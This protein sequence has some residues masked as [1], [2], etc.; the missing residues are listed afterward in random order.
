MG[1]DP[2]R[3]QGR[4][5]EWNCPTYKISRRA[6]RRRR[7]QKPDGLVRIG[8]AGGSRTHQHDFAV[9]AQAVARVLRDRSHCR[10]VLFRSADGTVPIL[11]VEEFPELQEIEDRIEW[12]N[13]VPLPQLPEKMVL[14]DVNLA[15]LETGN[16]FCEAKSELKFFEAALVDVPTIA[17]PTGP[18][19]RAIRDGATGFLAGSS[20]DWYSA[21]LRLIDDQ[22][23]R[24]RV[25]RA[26]HRTVLGRYGPFRRADAMLS[27]LPQFH[28]NSRD[29]TR[30]FALELHRGTAANL[31]NINIAEAVTVFDFDEFGDADLTVVIPLHNYA[32]YV[33]EAL[34]SVRAQTL[35]TLDL[36]VVE[37]ASTDSSLSLVVGWAERNARRF[38][39][40]L[41]LRNK[42]NAGLGTT[43]NT[44]VDAADTPFVLIGC[45]QQA[46][47]RMWRCLSFSRSGKRRCV[48]LPPTPTVR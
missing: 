41:V 33:E 24:R 48:C 2:L 22:G 26:A 3:G 4:S 40:I 5:R 47:A 31:S 39:R 13:F 7:W 11:D 32:Q 37:D 15:P 17:S 19:R 36:I 45:G 20:E 23:L 9:A 16:A 35:E 34:E 12:Q 14:F 28:G 38:N 27:A 18:F 30:A 44:G 46:A 6:V 43:R 29:A 1:W 8:Y 25:G 21:L 42:T 10:L